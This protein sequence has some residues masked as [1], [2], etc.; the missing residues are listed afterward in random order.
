MARNSDQNDIPDL[1]SH[2]MVLL[3]PIIML[4]VLMTFL[5]SKVDYESHLIDDFIIQLF[6]NLCDH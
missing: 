6:F 1:K 4:G 2:G 3:L 5:A